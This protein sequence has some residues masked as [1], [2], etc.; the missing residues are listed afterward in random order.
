MTDLVMA[1]DTVIS[2]AQQYLSAFT[3]FIH[4]FSSGNITVINVIR[5]P[6]HVSAILGNKL[7]SCF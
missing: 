2:N 6:F 1:D 4:L 5:I 3:G 7:I